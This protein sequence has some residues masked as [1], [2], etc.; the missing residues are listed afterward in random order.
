MPLPTDVP[1]S[2][3]VTVPVALPEDAVTVAVRVMDWFV[4]AGLGEATSVV[5]VVAAAGALTTSAKLDEVEA[6]SVVF[7]E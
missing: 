2:R 3:K 4:T 6:L 5:V 7:P 1:P